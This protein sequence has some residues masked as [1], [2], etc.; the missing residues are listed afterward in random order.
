MSTNP[1]VATL[2]VEC[3]IVNLTVML[4]F[5]CLLKSTVCVPQHSHQ[6]ASSSSVS[7]QPTSVPMTS[8]LASL[9][10]KLALS[11]LANCS[12]SRNTTFRIVH[13][14]P[15]P[16]SVTS[17]F[18]R[19]SNSDE[20]DTG[21]RASSRCSSA[22]SNCSS[23]TQVVAIK[24]P[25]VSSGQTKAHNN[26]KVQNPFNHLSSNPSLATNVS[27]DNRSHVKRSLPHSICLNNDDL[28]NTINNNNSVSLALSHDTN[29]NPV[30]ESNLLPSISRIPSLG[31]AYSKLG[32]R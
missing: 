12:V 3:M 28:I 10:S 8:R 30:T 4:P 31:S 24:I 21:D 26:F 16:P 32:T 2:L 20:D 1:V 29:D 27:T 18:P 6:T 25:A 9:Q 15:A 13:R 11:N 5:A 22:S 17:V 23:S 19:H 7:P 14:V